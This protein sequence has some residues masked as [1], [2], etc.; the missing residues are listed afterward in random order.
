MPIRSNEF[1]YRSWDRMERWQSPAVP[2]F[3]AEFRA[4]AA[5]QEGAEKRKIAEKMLDGFIPLVGSGKPGDSGTFTMA[6]RQMNARI[7]MVEEASRT[8]RCTR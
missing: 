8:T 4:I 3:L 7:G 2:T 6:H 1:L 5:G